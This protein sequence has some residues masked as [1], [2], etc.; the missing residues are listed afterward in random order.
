MLDWSQQY[1]G[2]DWVH[3]KSQPGIDR[4][5]RRFLPRKRDSQRQQ[6]SQD[7]CG[8]PFR[9]AAS[10]DPAVVVHKD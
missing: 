5:E 4:G 8:V 7:G 1:T 3:H 10:E 6:S 9:P 2:R